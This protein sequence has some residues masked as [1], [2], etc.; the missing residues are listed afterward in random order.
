MKHIMVILEIEGDE[1]VVIRSKEIM[2]DKDQ[3]I[4]HQIKDE[5]ENMD[6][7]FFR[8]LDLTSLRS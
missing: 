7:G 4:A 8:D 2:Q 5:L 1:V 3:D 6:L